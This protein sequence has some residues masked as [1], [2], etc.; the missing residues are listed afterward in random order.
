VGSE[1]SESEEHNVDVKFDVDARIETAVER[2]RMERVF[3]NLIGNALDVMPSGGSINIRGEAQD[4]QVLIAIEDTGPGIS[5]NA[6]P[7][8]FEPFSPSGKN[9]LGLGLALARQTVLDHGGDL[10]AEPDAPG[11]G[12]RFLLRLPV[13]GAP[14]RKR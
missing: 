1:R 11:R 5:P 14:P 4:G 8:L 9:G 3:V 10:W 12:A 6:R 7:K 2:A 13:D